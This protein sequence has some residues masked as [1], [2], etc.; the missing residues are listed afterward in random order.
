MRRAIWWAQPPSIAEISAVGAG[1]ALMAGALWAS[2]FGGGTCQDVARWAVASGTAAAMQ[3]GSSM[4]TRAQIEEVYSQV[5]LSA[6]D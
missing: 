1:D 2:L 5:R 6:L 3:D 4:P